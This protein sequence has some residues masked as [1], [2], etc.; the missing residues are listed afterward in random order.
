MTDFFPAGWF[1]FWPTMVEKGGRRWHRVRPTGNPK[2]P[3]EMCCTGVRIGAA[4][5]TK[6]TWTDYP[7]RDGFCCAKTGA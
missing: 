2:F 6:G 1:L 5:V 3:L 4:G 7:Q